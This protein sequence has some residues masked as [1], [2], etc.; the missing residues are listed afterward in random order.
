M[1]VLVP[2][3]V[4][5]SSWKGINTSFFFLC[6]SYHASVLSALEVA[7][8]LLLYFIS[9]LSSSN[10]TTTKKKDGTGLVAQESYTFLVSNPSKKERERN[11]QVNFSCIFFYFYG[12][13]FSSLAA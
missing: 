2:Q 4:I 9:F 6:S 7:I 11:F 8:L 12:L 10:A 5:A 13:F 1:V 3:G